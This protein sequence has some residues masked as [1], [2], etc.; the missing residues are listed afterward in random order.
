M[1]YRGLKYFLLLC[2]VSIP[3]T[4]NLAQDDMSNM[5]AEVQKWNDNFAKAMMNGD[6]EKL[7]SM[8]ADDAYSLPSYSPMVEG[9][10]ALKKAMMMDKESGNKMTEFKL[11]TLD[12]F[13]SGN[14]LVEVGKYHLT[15]EMKNMRDPYHDMG[16]YVTIYEKQ[17]DG[18]YKIKADIWNTDTNPWKMMEKEGDEGDEQ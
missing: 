9:K 5:K 4:K 10:N 11:E 15:M 17:A 1:F 6:D 13:G 3:V 18:S 14:L 16:K 8:Y 7:L 2:I 12:V